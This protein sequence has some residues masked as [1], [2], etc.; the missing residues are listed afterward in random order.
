MTWNPKRVWCFCLWN[1]SFRIPLLNCIFLWWPH[2]PRG[3]FNS[4]ISAPGPCPADLGGGIHIPWNLRLIWLGRILKIFF[5]PTIPWAG[6]ASSGPD[7]SKPHP[8]ILV[9]HFFSQVFKMLCLL[10]KKFPVLLNNFQIGRGEEKNQNGLP[11]EAVGQP[12][13]A[14][15]GWWRQ[16]FWPWGVSD[17]EK[18]RLCP[19]TI[20]KALL[21]H[22]WRRERD[23]CHLLRLLS[24]FL[25]A[26]LS[27]FTFHFNLFN[28]STPSAALLCSWFE[29]AP[30]NLGEFSFPWWQETLK[31]IIFPPEFY[32]F[33]L[34]TNRDSD[35]KR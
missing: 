23:E 17:L 34:D 13:C 11:R 18:C 19:S 14:W 25:A 29:A 16:L 6:T 35:F 4:Q 20:P 30:V 10:P 26:F 2:A 22:G 21:E 3:G 12:R 15:P 5:V 9:S 7:C 27:A 28:S 8:S 32:E 33:T 1:D 31:F 24:A